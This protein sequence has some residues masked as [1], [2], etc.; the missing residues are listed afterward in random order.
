MPTKKKIEKPYNGGQWTQARF[1]SFIK[2]GL[3]KL[4]MKW[5]PIN[6]CKKDA[7]V[8]RGVYRCAI[9]GKDVPCS[10]KEKGKRK[11][12]VFVDHIVPIISPEM[13]FE[14]WD[15]TISRMFCEKENLQLVCRSCHTLKTQEEQRIAKERR[16]CGSK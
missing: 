8:S 3:R 11:Q 4:S 12:N 1:N 2:S 9:C 7:R 13:G 16:F 5:G 15:T 10:I 6:Q 14:S